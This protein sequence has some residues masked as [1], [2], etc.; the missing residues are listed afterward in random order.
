MMSGCPSNFA[1]DG[2]M[3]RASTSAGPPG[4]KATSMVTGLDGKVSAA[5]A[6]PAV[7]ALTTSAAARAAMPA[8]ARAM[9][10]FGMSLMGSSSFQTAWSGRWTRGIAWNKL[11][12]VASVRA[13]ATF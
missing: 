2:C 4:G 13:T 8:N 5:S 12:G 6:G 9:G 1:I 11:F 10:V 7:A 3:A